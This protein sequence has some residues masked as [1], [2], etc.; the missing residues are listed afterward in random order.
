MPGGFIPSCYVAFALYGRR[1]N[2]PWFAWW[3]AGSW[4]RLA[5]HAWR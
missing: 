1:S 2:R 4:W 5:L 3:W